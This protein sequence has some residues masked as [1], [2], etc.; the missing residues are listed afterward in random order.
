MWLEHMARVFP[1]YWFFPLDTEYAYRGHKQAKSTR[2]I[3]VM[4]CYGARL[5]SCSLHNSIQN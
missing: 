1:E 2:T 3:T 4:A 5:R